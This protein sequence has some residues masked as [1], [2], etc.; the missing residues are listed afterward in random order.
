M[1]KT[2][3]VLAGALAL[4]A[5]SLAAQLPAQA[6]SSR[7][8]LIADTAASTLPASDFSAARRHYR[9]YRGSRYR[10]YRRAPRYYYAPYDGG[11]YAPG[12]YYRPYYA[13][14][15]FPLFPFFW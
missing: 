8:A 13:P 15:P 3:T 2:W 14:A 7:S 4:G 5:V 10:V 1:R 6:A 12:Y 9:H 11:Y